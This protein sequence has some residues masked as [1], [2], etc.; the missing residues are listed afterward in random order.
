M[1]TTQT[2]VQNNFQNLNKDY[3]KVVDSMKQKCYNKTRKKHNAK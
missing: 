2:I 3:K 1:E